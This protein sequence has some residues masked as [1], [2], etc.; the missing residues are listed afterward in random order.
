[1]K[2]N[3]AELRK[4]IYDF[5]SISNRLMQA[6]FQDYNSVLFKFINFIKNNDLIYGYIKG[7]GECDQDLEKEF[8]EVA[9]SYGGAIFYL[10]SHD[11]EEIRNVFAIL[12]YIVEN[13]IEIHYRLAFGYSASKKYQDKVKG[14][15][16]RVVMVLIRH[17]ERYLTKIGIDM[18]IDEK[19]TYSITIENGQV[20]IANDNSTINATNTI[21][22]IDSEKLNE[23]IKDIKGNAKGLSIEDEETLVSSLDVIKE[24]SKSPNPRRSFLKTAVLGLQ[25]VKGTVEFAAAVTTLIQ[26]IQPML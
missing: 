3:R 19:V 24:E 7:C 14:F 13:D 16:D 15:N 10:G 23:L 11:D 17:I 21:N 22:T 20:N 18:G 26:F 9:E 4:I 1:M 25:T 5:N 12:N 8:K 6:D 2:L